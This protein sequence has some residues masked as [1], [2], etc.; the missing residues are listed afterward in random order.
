MRGQRSG[1]LAES[2]RRAARLGSW[3]Y[4]AGVRGRE[5]AYRKGLLPVKR[6]PRPT[7]C[8][9][10]ITVGGTGKTPLVIRLVNDL[11]AE[12]IRPAVLLRGYKREHAVSRP[13]LVRDPQAIRASVRE[14]GDE[15][16]ELAAR[17]P[18]ACVGVGADRYAV[19]RFIL[20]RFPVDCFVMDDG[21]QHYRLHRDLNIVT[22]D[23]T[24]PW[25]GGRLL[26]AGLL[27]EAPQSLQRADWVVLTRTGL[28]APDRLAVLR[29]EVSSLV[30]ETTA[31][32]ESRYEPRSLIALS[33]RKEHPL[34]QLRGKSVLAVS[35]I[36]NPQSFEMS[37]AALG[38]DITASLR[39]S[40]H[41]GRPPDVWTWIAKHRQRGQ[42][43]LMT[44]KDAMRWTAGPIPAGSLADAFALRMDLTLT[45]GEPLWR[46]MIEGIK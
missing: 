16:M 6:L 7:L 20:E 24:D 45:S 43:V 41:G 25:G 11:L 23:V 33:G 21:F 32:L 27:R 9:G 35:G 2:F 19:G 12:G 34:S 8:V 18:K 10:N 39:L 15:A 28:V 31:V 5:L 26:P 36:A 22:L 3:G 13:V 40:D 37:A 4:R 1:V 46:G 29:A 42:W 14:A 17:L 38:A 30:R 44:E